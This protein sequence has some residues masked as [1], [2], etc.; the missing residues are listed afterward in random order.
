MTDNITSHT[1][2]LISESPYIN[3]TQH[4]LASHAKVSVY[5][6]IRYSPEC[7]RIRC[8]TGYWLI[9]LNTSNDNEMEISN[10]YN[11]PIVFHWV[12]EAFLLWVLGQG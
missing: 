7:F 10:I 12:F 11:T 5:T 9:S 2:D 4:P 6:H 8:A 3:N 1:T